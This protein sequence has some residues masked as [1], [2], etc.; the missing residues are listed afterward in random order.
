MA[1]DVMSRT[2]SASG[3]LLG[4]RFL[5]KLIDL[6]LILI[7][8][9]IL[10]PEDFAI[11]AM[12]LIFIQ[13]TE[14]ILDIPVTQALI[15]APE[16]PDSMLDTAFTI[17]LLRGVLLMVVVLGFAPLAVYVFEEPRLGSL[18]LF[19]ALSPAIRGLVNPKLVMYARRLNYFPEAIIDVV[20]KVLTTFVAIPIALWTGSYWSLAIMA[21]MSAFAIM[22]G[23]YIFAPYRPRLSLKEWPVFSDMIS[24]TTVSQ[25]FVAANW[26]VDIFVLG[27]SVA[28]DIIGKYSMSQTLSGAPFQVFVVPV[29]RPFVAAFAELREPKAIS[30][31]YLTASS[32]VFTAVAPILV[33]MVILSEPIIMLLFDEAWAGATLFLAVLAVSGVIQLPSQPVASVALAL[34]RARFNALQAFIGLA[35]KVPLLFLGLKYFGLSGFL[36]GQ[37]AGVTAWTIAGAFIVRHLV[38]LSIR[39]Q[40]RSLLRPLAGIAALCAAAWALGPVLIDT[41]SLMLMMTAGIIGAA[42]MAAYWTVVMLLWRRAGQPDG[43]EKLLAGGAS[44]AGAWFGR[45]VLQKG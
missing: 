43:I 27:R 3:A 30:G 13:F 20:A 6:V 12:A 26:Q 2:A 38:G 14:S 40:I 11:V 19:L 1:K 44:K 9:R 23:S 45:R 18:M 8:A 25:V 33:L 22:I 37:I 29:M 15:R 42:G 36:A 39:D 24:W 4:A 35:V 28:D 10:A 21:V 31:G 41:S 17:S 7:L 32:S 16:V 5:H 34:D